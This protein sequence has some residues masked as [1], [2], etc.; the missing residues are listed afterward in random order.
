MPSLREQ[1]VVYSEHVVISALNSKHSLA[2]RV[3]MNMKP[4]CEVI[5]T[6]RQGMGKKTQFVI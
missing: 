5:V 1:K 3:V 2:V 6:T 4:S